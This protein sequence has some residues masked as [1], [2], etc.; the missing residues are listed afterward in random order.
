MKKWFIVDFIIE[1]IAII[2][3]LVFLIY[4]I[5]YSEYNIFGF[6]LLFI[7]INTIVLYILFSNYIK[8]CDLY[9]SDYH[10]FDISGK[11][12]VVINCKKD[13]SSYFLEYDGNEIEF[14]TSERLFGNQMFFAYIVRNIRFLEVSKKRPLI[15]IFK[16]KI[17]LK[18]IKL[19]NLTVILNG[20]KYLLVSNGISKSK[21]TLINKSWY[22]RY[23]LSRRAIA[24][25]MVKNTNFIDENKFQKGKTVYPNN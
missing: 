3:M 11:E 10:F 7:F 24:A 19:K 2:S 17:R 6:L 1:I 15:Y 16:R 23:F 20:K 8:K 13:K 5:I 14:R 9:I 12:N 25:S 18:N 4:G 21:F 22:W